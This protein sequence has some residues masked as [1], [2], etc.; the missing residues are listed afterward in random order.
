MK[1]L[2]LIRLHAENKTEAMNNLI[3]FLHCYNKKKIR[4]RSIEGSNNY[5]EIEVSYEDNYDT[6][7]VFDSKDIIEDDVKKLT[8]QNQS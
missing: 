6:E 2:D 5:Y 8:Y 3:V 4:V 7:A 1:H